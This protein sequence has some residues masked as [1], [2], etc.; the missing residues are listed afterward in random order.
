MI[1]G[2]TPTLLLTLT[3]IDLEHVQSVHVTLRNGALQWDF[4]DVE[5]DAEHST[6][7]VFLT[8]EQSLQLSTG[9]PLEIQVN[10]LDGTGRRWASDIG[11]VVIE[12]QLL[13][14]VIE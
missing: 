10:G 13:N 12:G 11:A 6:I 9:K 2:T 4:T 1:R 8:Q 14:E 3:G 7:G 5:I